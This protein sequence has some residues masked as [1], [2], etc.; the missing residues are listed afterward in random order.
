MTAAIAEVEPTSVVNEDIAVFEVEDDRMG[1]A[2][3]RFL[4]HGGGLAM[5]V[6]IHN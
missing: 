5:V 2:I 1:V 4:E 6:M 3:R